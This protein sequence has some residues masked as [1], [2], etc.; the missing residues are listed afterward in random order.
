MESR[1]GDR[2]HELTSGDQCPEAERQRRKPFKNKQLHRMNLSRIRGRALSSCAGRMTADFPCLWRELGV[3]EG[4]SPTGEWN[5]F[6]GYRFYGH[7]E[8]DLV[9]SITH[10]GP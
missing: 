9:R 5:N 4:R 2:Q 10:I 8:R 7:E 1:L 3:M 6:G